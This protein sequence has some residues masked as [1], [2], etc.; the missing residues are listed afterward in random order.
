LL[1]RGAWRT[2][3]NAALI[4]IETNSFAERLQQKPQA[5]TDFIVA[6]RTLLS[7]FNV[8]AKSY[9]GKEIG[10]F[11]LESHLQEDKLTEIT[12]RYPKNAVV[13]V[14]FNPQFPEECTL[15]PTNMTEF[16]ETR[17]LGLILFAFGLV[18]IVATR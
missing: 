5:P 18:A 6:R 9:I 16:Y 4:S 8:G 14:Y 10:L 2:L 7:I 3:V 17:N 1:F 12:R 15:E 13:T 11:G